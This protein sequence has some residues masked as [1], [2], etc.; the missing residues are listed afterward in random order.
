M[1]EYIYLNLNDISN[2]HMYKDRPILLRDNNI[3]KNI[4]IKNCF[5]DEEMYERF[6]IWINNA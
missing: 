4:M 2:W 5:V 1:K 6:W 3:I